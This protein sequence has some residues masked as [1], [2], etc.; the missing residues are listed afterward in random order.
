[1]LCRMGRFPNSLLFFC[2]TKEPKRF[3]AAHKIW[4]KKNRVKRGQN[5]ILSEPQAKSKIISSVRPLGSGRE[6]L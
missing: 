2:A 1:M 3:L 6:L 5:E 4:R